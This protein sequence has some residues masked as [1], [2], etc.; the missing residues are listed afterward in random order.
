[1]RNMFFF[2]FEFITE[3][4]IRHTTLTHTHTYIHKKGIIKYEEIHDLCKNSSHK[5][6][7]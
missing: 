6:Y 5:Y 1:M 2:L 4:D 3:D 7:S